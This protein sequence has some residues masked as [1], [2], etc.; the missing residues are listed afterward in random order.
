MILPWSTV[1]HKSSFVNLAVLSHAN[2]I[3]LQ[4]VNVARDGALPLPIP[5]SW[6]EE[7]REGTLM[8]LKAAAQPAG[9]PVP[10]MAPTNLVCEAID[11]YVALEAAKERK[12]WRTLD[13]FLQ[14]RDWYR[15]WSELYKWCETYLCDRKSVI[16]LSKLCFL[17][18]L[19]FLGRK[20]CA[21]NINEWN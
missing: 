8:R 2:T 3:V 12:S 17:N 21:N 15:V 18:K 4:S 13:P 1:G 5:P 7:W 9:E 19:Q 6:W 20:D 14:V 10:H 11:Q 16:K